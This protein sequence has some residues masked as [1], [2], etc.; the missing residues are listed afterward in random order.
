MELKKFQFIQF[1]DTFDMIELWTEMISS[2]DTASR[3]EGISVREHG[4]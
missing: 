2:G 1:L 3:R 4:W